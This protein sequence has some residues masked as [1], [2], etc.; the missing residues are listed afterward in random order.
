M[1][2]SLKR[3]FRRVHQRRL[4]FCCDRC[5]G[6]GKDG[7]AAGAAAAAADRLLLRLAE[8]SAQKE[9]RAEQLLRFRNKNLKNK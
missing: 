6:R 4:S 7:R 9:V 5:V 3:S 2:P 1:R 8:L